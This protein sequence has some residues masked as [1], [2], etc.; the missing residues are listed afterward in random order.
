MEQGGENLVYSVWQSEIK[1]KEKKKYRILLYMWNLHAC[2]LSHFSRVWLFVT[3]WTVAHQAPPSMGFS[4]QKCWNGLPCPPPGDLPTQGSNP[5]LLHCRQTLY[6]LS[7]QGSPMWNLEN[8]IMILFA[9]QKQRHRRS[10]QTCGH[11]RGWGMWNDP[12]DWDRLHTL[13]VLCIK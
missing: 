1:Q 2:M 10:E 9:K 4:R 7:H 6:H 13:L 8:G 11:Q 3:S 5:G 12:G